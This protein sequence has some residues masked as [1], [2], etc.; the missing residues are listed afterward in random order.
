[1][2]SL[3][4]LAKGALLH[5]LAR[6]VTGRGIEV[7]ER[8]AVRRDLTQVGFRKACRGLLV[9][10]MAAAAIAGGG[11]TIVAPALGGKFMIACSGE[12]FGVGW[13]VL[14]HGVYEPHLVSFYERTLRAG[15]TVLDVGANIGF[16]ALHAARL[17]GPSGRVLAIEPDPA[18][19]ALLRT[20]LAH[21]SGMRVELIEVAL[22]DADGEVIL[23]DLGNAANSGARFTHPDRAALEALVHGPDPSFRSVPARRFDDLGTSG[24]IHLVK[25]DVEGFEPRVVRGMERMLARCRPMVVSEFAPSN[26]RTLGGIEPDAYLEWFRSRGYDVRILD[27]APEAPVPATRAALAHALR[28]RHHVDLL[29]APA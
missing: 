11:M 10:R 5:G 20:S 3:R 17:V 27:D 23:T 22:S 24:E 15:M 13:E 28:N 25:I 2:T 1:M 18:N 21:N 19:A 26:L 6:A 9:R 12:D 16:H 8:D 29:F 7:A 4:N 14:E